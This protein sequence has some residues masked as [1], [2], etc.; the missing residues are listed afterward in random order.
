MRLAYIGSKVGSYRCRVRFFDPLL[1]L[2]CSVI[3]YCSESGHS[4]K[5]IEGLKYLFQHPA[6]LCFGHPIEFSFT[7]DEKHRMIDMVESWRSRM[8]HH[9]FKFYSDNPFLFQELLRFVGLKNHIFQSSAGSPTCPPC[10][11]ALRLSKK[12]FCVKMPLLV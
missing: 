6:K 3:L 2:P 5:T 8:I 9:V 11:W 1:A 12:N 10:Q 4:K 7:L